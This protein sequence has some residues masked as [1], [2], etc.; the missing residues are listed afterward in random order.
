MCKVL[1]MC[2]SREEKFEQMPMEQSGGDVDQVNEE[3]TK[4]VVHHQSRFA[5][6]MVWEFA[7]RVVR[8]QH[9]FFLNISVP[10][11]SF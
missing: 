7:S 9:R 6:T 3:E 1:G 8:G 2:I 11:P 4:A 10:N 5:M